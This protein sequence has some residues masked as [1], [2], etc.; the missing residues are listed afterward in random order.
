MCLEPGEGGNQPRPAAPPLLQH[1]L[2]PGPIYSA[3]ASGPLLFPAVYLVSLSSFSATHTAIPSL[4]NTL[5]HLLLGL[6]GWG[7]GVAEQAKRWEFFFFFCSFSNVHTPYTP[8]THPRT[9]PYYPC[10]PP[11]AYRSLL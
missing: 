9:S 2:S 3:W 7:W 1:H 10:K 11:L 6:G 5:C 8:P 4:Q